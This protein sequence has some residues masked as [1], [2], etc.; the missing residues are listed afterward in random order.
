MSSFYSPPL[1]Q[2]T[3]LSHWTCM[4][5]QFYT[6]LIAL[7]RGIWLLLSGRTTLET[8]GK[9]QGAYKLTATVAWLEHGMKSKTKRPF[10][11][12]G[13]GHM[14]KC[15]IAC[16]VVE[17][18]QATIRRSGT[19]IKAGSRYQQVALLG[20]TNHPFIHKYPALP[21]W[22]LLFYSLRWRCLCLLGAAR[23]CPFCVAVVGVV[24]CCVC[25]SVCL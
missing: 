24:L 2:Q 25:L 13:V 8:R 17:I 23:A 10:V 5:L 15:L 21:A 16:H 1:I 9:F 7:T 12:A 4:C 6:S 19:Q 11:C 20:I 14:P 18:Q 3:L 22:P